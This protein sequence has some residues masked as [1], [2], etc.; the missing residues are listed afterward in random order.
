[1]LQAEIIAIG[2]ELLTPYRSDT[3]SLWLT[4]QLNAL[5]IS[6]RQKTI[7]GD[8]EQCLEDA[9][10]D[11]LKRS[12][13]IISTGGLGPTEDDI[14]RKVFSRVLKRPL[15]LH[16]DILDHIRK[17]FESR[18]MKMS[19]NNERQALVPRGAEVL[20]NPNGTA[21]GI[22]I[23]EGTQVIAM[24]PGPPREM[25]PM[26]TNYV[27]PVLEPLA[28]GKRLRQRV[29]R[30][31]GMG[32]SAVDNLIA[33]VYSRYTNPLTTILFNRTD[34]EIHLTASA[35]TDTEADRL[36]DEVAVQIEE[37]LGENLFA[38]QGE[39]MEQVM[40]LKLTVK[41]YTIATAESCTGGLL[42]MRLTE[43]P[44][45][46]NYFLQGVV[47]YSNQSKTDLLGVSPELIETQ[48]AVSPEVAEAMARGIKQR[49][50]A[51][52]GVGITGI[53]GPDGGS[54]EKPVG[55]VYIGLADDVS[56]SHKK[57]LLPGDR[58]R[59]RWLTSQAA[60]DLVRRRYLL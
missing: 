55:L 5:G 17:L 23:R 12:S 51:T 19:S 4:S 29:M 3:N 20:R 6:L 54:P 38:H 57:L 37:K 10:R 22:L 15:I 56:V 42:A 31:S 59:I 33:P 47:S 9:L 18:N 53:A 14:T 27:R 60:M 36:I 58:E 30:V 49:S 35:Q 43:V 44:G 13:M 8:D 21:P 45:S 11:A 1:M 28:G 32:E 46:S 25:Q 52:I 7:V 50:G 24:L 40:A 2:S 34:I 26:F 39:T 41:G 16:Q 48:G